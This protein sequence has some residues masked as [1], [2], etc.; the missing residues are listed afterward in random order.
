MIEITW[1]WNVKCQDWNWMRMTWGFYWIIPCDL[2]SGSSAYSLY[3]C[4]QLDWCGGRWGKSGW[5]KT[6]WKISTRGHRRWTGVFWRDTSR[7]DVWKT[8]APTAF[9]CRLAMFAE[10]RRYFSDISHVCSC[11]F[12]A[13]TLQ[14]LLQIGQYR[15]SQVAVAIL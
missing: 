6:F 14:H 1:K 15:R 8:M 7:H 11:F 12:A 9:Q 2:W 4:S 5:K 13:R 3:I 10:P